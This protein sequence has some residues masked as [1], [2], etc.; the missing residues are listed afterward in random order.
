[1]AIT[2]EQLEERKKYIGASEAAA[3]LG[4]SRYDTPLGIWAV[5]TGQLAPSEEETLPM[6]V[7][8][9]SEAM[10]AKRFMLETGKKVRRVNDTLYHKKY[11]FLACHLDRKV[12][13]EGAILECKTANAFKYR[14]WEDDIPTEYIVQVYH[15]L[16]CSGYKKA[17]IACLIGNAKF[18]VK[19]IFRD[20]KVI[21]DMI[22]K[23][24]SFWNDF[25]IPKILP[26]QIMAADDDVLYKLFPITSDEEVVELT[27]QANMICES[28][29]SLQAD[30][31]VIKRQIEEQKN[32]LKVM[33]GE[34]AVGSTGRYKVSWRNQSQERLDTK[35][36]REEE[37]EIASKYQKIIETRVLRISQIKE[38]EEGKNHDSRKH[39]KGNK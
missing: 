4:L 24:V 36:F 12:E 35:R 21:N 38:K 32:E 16:A 2:K 37:P 28:I 3:V 8:T 10:V 13:G 6:W 15:E 29:D 19:E 39:E 26:G 14:E 1:M 11:P 33:L 9:E 20:E 23:E 17:Y 27:D 31:K 34:H 7:G 25:V 22:K 30:A 5:K 18:V